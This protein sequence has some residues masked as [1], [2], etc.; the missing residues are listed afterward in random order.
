MVAACIS[1]SCLVSKLE[2]A[3]GH[4]SIAMVDVSGLDPWCFEASLGCKDDVDE[5]GEDIF[6]NVGVAIGDAGVTYGLLLSGDSSTDVNNLTAA[7]PWPVGESS[8]S[9]YGGRL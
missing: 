2:A 7:A 5:D 3:P 6:R 4:S 8:S 9:S 1:V